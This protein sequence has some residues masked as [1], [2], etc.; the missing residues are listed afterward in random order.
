MSTYARSNHTATAGQTSFIVD[1]ADGLIDVGSNPDT[2]QVYVNDILEPA[3]SVTWTSSTTLELSGYVC[4][5]DDE[6]QFRR[7]TH[8]DDLMVDFTGGTRIRTTTLDRDLRQLLHAVHESVDVTVNLQDLE[9]SVNDSEAAAIAAAASASADS[10]SASNSEAAAAASASAINYQKLSTLAELQVYTGIADL[11]YVEGRTSPEDGYHGKFKKITGVD[12]SAEV[13]LDTLNAFYVTFPSDP[14]GATGAWVRQDK[15]ITPEK[16]GAVG[17]GI[18]DDGLAVKEMAAYANSVNSHAVLTDGKTYRITA[19]TFGATSDFCPVVAQKGATLSFEGDIQAE[20]YDGFSLHNVAIITDHSYANTTASFYYLFTAQERLNNPVFCNVS[21]TCTTAA[22]DGSSRGYGLINVK[23]GVYNLM[24]ENII[25]SGIRRCF[26]VEEVD[27]TTDNP[28]IAI[29]SINGW[30]S[31]NC[32]AGM[33]LGSP[34]SGPI[35]YSN[36]GIII[37]DYTFVNTETQSNNYSG[38]ARTGHSAIIGS[39]GVGG[40]MS[41]LRIRNP[42]EHAAYIYARDLAVTNLVMIDAEDFKVVGYDPTYRSN[43]IEIT[44]IT[45]ELTRVPHETA[46]SLLTTYY[47]DGFKASS[48]Q[49]RGT[50]SYRYQSIMA[51]SRSATDIAVSNVDGEYLNYGVVQC[52]T[53]DSWESAYENITISEC[54][55]KEP[56]IYSDNTYAALTF[57]LSYL[58]TGHNTESMVKGL[59][60]KNNVFEQYEGGAKVIGR[61]TSH[62]LGLIDIFNMEDVTLS[63]NIINGYANAYGPIKTGDYISN[64]KVDEKW[65]MDAQSVPR[66]LDNTIN[67]G[68]QPVEISEGST[69]KLIGKRPGSGY[70]QS[71]NFKLTSELK[72]SESAGSLVVDDILS[73]GSGRLEAVYDLPAAATESNIMAYG[74]GIVQASTASGE[75]LLAHWNRGVLT[76]I[77]QSA[78]FAITDT[79]SKVCLYSSGVFAVLKN[80]LASAERVKLTWDLMFDE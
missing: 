50:S 3:A 4:Q 51:L 57:Y 71:A 68:T 35:T 78:N 54:R 28:P 8:K 24:I 11:I 39:M 60:I 22:S 31:I 23:Y 64:I 2:V 16:F 52:L 1:F 10:I 61:G 73:S 38:G 6:I 70:A 26:V 77:S 19:A 62:M 55:I 17:D 69:L 27:C 40:R 18:T 34:S 25:F 5:A 42:V 48:I 37:N 15:I 41:N 21:Y 32:Q 49:Y 63:G 80:N 72:E 30:F 53:D 44:G 74:R 58:P 65:V 13:A 79:A 46:Q 67:G 45:S 75:Y 12:Y 20:V 59:T 56:C 47:T 33:Y 14:A 9:D 7:I 36:Y 29:G 43:N 76:V 66:F